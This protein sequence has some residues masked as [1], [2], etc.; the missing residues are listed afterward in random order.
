M[1]AVGFLGD[2]YN[3]AAGPRLNWTF[4]TPG[5]FSW[6]ALADHQI[7]VL[8]T[9]NRIEPLQSNS[10]WM[11]PALEELLVRYVEE[12]GSLLSFHSGL[13]SYPAG[14]YTSLVGGAFQFH[15]VAYPQFRFV[16]RNEPH[17]IL[18]GVATFELTD[19]MY[20]VWRDAATTE[21]LGTLVSEEYGSSSALWCGRR[22]RGKVAG[23]TPGHR[24]EA[25]ARPS[26][27]RLVA[28]ILGWFGEGENA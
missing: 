12:G 20:F 25:L 22:G 21:G 14:P 27:V 16:P 3:E 4:A 7:V 19:E 26:V 18:Q 2:F 15:P 10:L 9:E 24:P 17:S 13:A 8:G 28:N 11:T 6:G 23:L 5:E 1:K